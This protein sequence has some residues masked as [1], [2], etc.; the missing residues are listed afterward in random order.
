MPIQDM[1]DDIL[2]FPQVI[3]EKQTLDVFDNPHAGKIVERLGD[4]TQYIVF[5]VVTECACASR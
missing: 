3:L 4:D 5:S 2:S 1:P